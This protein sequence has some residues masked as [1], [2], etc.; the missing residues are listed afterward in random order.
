MLS[1]HNAASIV[2][3]PTAPSDPRLRSLLAEAVAQWTA[4]N[5][6]SLTHVLV[7]EPGDTEEAIVREVGFSPLVNPIDGAR[8]GSIPHWDWLQD[9]GGWF[10]LI[11]TVGN[12]GFAF[13]LFIQDAEG[14]PAL[15]ELC[16]QGDL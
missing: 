15:L 6:L 3:C 4:A 8:H 12:S 9:R 14:D 7:I 10:Q 1:F 13:V 5:L 2:A 16:R 11:I